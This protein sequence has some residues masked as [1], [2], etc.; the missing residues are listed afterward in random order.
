MGMEWVRK[1]GVPN[2]DW[3]AITKVI[4]AVA[5]AENET[6]EDCSEKEGGSGLLPQLSHSGPLEPRGRGGKYCCH[7]STGRV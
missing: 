2:G 1:W 3:G 6:A 4:M 5:A 7:G